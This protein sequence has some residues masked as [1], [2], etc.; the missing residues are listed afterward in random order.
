MH[1]EYTTFRRRTR[2][3]LFDPDAEGGQRLSDRLEEAGLGAH[4]D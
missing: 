1:T 3:I 2:T 4:G